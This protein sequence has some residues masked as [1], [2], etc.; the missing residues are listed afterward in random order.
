MPTVEELNAAAPDTPVFVLYLYSRGFLNQ[1]ALAALGI[2]AD[3][4]APMGGRFE[5]GPDGNPTGVLL[6]EPNPTILYRTIGALPGMSLDEQINSTRHFFR[7]LNRFGLTSA[8]DAGGGGHMFPENYEATKTLAQRSELTVRISYYLFPQ[9]PGQELKDFQNWMAANEVGQDNARLLAN[10]Y[11]L[12][13]AGEFLVWSAGDFENFMAPRPRLGERRNW[14]GELTE[15]TRLLVE[16]RWPFRIHATYGESIS[17]IFDVFDKVN[18]EIPFNGLRWALDHAE[19]ISS[20]DI[21][22]IKA[23]GGGVA[24]QNRMAFAGEYFVE[25]Y[26]KE[27]AAIAPP[28][29]GLVES[30][31]PLGV[32]TD[33]TRVSS[34]NPWL[35]LY[36]LVTGKTV[37]G[38]PLYGPEN[39]LTRAEA[40][41]LYTIG[42]AWFSG[43]EE[44]KG[45][46]IP[47]QYADMTLL[48]EDYFAV[49]EEEIREIESILTIVDGE[50]VYAAEEFAGLVEPLPAV[51]PE[52]SPVARYGGYWSPSANR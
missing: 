38:T 8:I 21:E 24:I 17:Q 2:D 1:A 6:A 52:W 43:E 37:A 19:T 50:V 32:G 48:T 36:W 28:I 23:L 9:R 18:K 7:E 51:S 5:R 10:G 40:L 3:T 45:R 41:R 20:R 11:A 39:T 30:G 22:R 15:V 31:V 26:G 4:V 25:R 27:A 29:R 33:G 16:N 49:S 42:S 35:S 46:L 34:Y 13:G 14:A 44:L 12:E 47:G